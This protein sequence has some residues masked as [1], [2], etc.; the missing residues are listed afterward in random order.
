MALAELIDN[1]IQAEASQ[2]HVILH[3]ESDSSLIS[4]AVVDDGFGMSGTQIQ[5]AIRF[6]GSTRFNDRTGLGRFGMGLPNSSLSQSRCFDVYSWTSPDAVLRV[7]LDIDQLVASAEAAIDP[8]VRCA[9]PP[10]VPVETESGT[11]VVWNQCDRLRYRRVSTLERKTHRRLGQI[12]RYAIWEGLDLRINR[13]RVV[14]YDPLF[15]RTRVQ[16]VSATLYRGPLRY[17]LRTSRTGGTGTV[18]VRFTLL[19]VDR[20]HSLSSSAKK[21]MGITGGAGVSIVR[22]GREI[23]YGWHLLGGKRRENYDQ[24]WRCEIRF[25]PAL[26]DLFGVT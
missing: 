7:R 21:Q 25:E 18:E 11:A 4:I 26:D 2:V 16:N 8:P 6:G 13:S 23:D 20:W 1:S 3:N 22:A 14:A 10:W 5:E 17:D 15:L 24:W 12:S 19:P 9:P